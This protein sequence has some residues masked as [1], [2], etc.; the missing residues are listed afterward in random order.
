M[1]RGGAELDLTVFFA[2]M[3]LPLGTNFWERWKQR[4]GQNHF[5]LV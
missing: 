4:D 1:K 2:S 3:L 5:I